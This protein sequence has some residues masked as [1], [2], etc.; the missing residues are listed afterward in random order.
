[1]SQ[2]AWRKSSFSEGHTDTCV[3]IATDS[4]GTRHL[5]ESDDPEVVMATNPAALRAFL[6]AAKAGESHSTPPRPVPL[7]AVLDLTQLMHQ[8]IPGGTPNPWPPAVRHRHWPPAHGCRHPRPHQP[9]RRPATRPA[10][11]RL[12]VL[13]RFHVLPSADSHSS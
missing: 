1:M 4:T 3:E 11:R 13:Q 2:L 8:A 7:A 9:A 10:P 6:R 5:R 12:L